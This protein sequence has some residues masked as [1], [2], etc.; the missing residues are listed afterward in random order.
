LF[1]S[2]NTVTFMQFKVANTY[3]SLFPATPTLPPVASNP[4]EDGVYVTLDQ[5]DGYQAERDEVIEKV[6]GAAEAPDVKKVVTIAGD[7]HS[8]IAGYIR[9]DFNDTTSLPQNVQGAPP[10]PDAVGVWFVCGSVTSANLAEL[11]TFGRGR[12]G[13]PDDRANASNAL[14]E[15]NNRHFKYFNSETHGYN[16]M[17]VTPEKLTCTIK[18]VSIAKQPEAT[19]STLKVFEVPDGVVRI[20]DVTPAP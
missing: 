13:L 17:A 1:F 12:S 4:G 7:T 8:F 2:I 3:L 6:G 5:W 20:N 19:L 14:V 18:V 9:R 10:P 11:A 16:V 15:S